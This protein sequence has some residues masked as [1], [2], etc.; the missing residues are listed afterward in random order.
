MV[1]N[2]IRKGPVQIQLSSEQPY[3][4]QQEKLFMRVPTEK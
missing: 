2:N 3:Y 1:E 4:S